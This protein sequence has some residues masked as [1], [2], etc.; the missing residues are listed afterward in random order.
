MTEPGATPDRILA[1]CE[2]VIA[3]GGLARFRMQ[4]VAREAGVSIGLLSYHFG[5][6]AGLLQAALDHVAANGENHTAG[7]EE[8]TPLARLRASLRAD[9]G[10][11][12]GVREGSITWNEVRANAVFD[13]ANAAALTRSTANWQDAM[14]ALIAEANPADSRPGHTALL[15]TSL[16]EGLSGRWL[17]GQIDAEA[18]RAAID[19]AIDVTVAH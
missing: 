19:A 7:P 10:N 8:L 9:F 3:R 14:A 12:P 1:A 6:R 4:D 2:R 11:E 15:L 18:A 5:D 16:V 17:T 13:T